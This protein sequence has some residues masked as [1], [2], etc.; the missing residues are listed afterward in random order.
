LRTLPKREKFSSPDAVSALRKIAKLSKWHSFLS[1]HPDPEKRAD[2]L[3]TQ[4]EGKALS[5]EETQQS[6]ISKIKVFLENNF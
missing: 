5:I 2:R 3:Q 4:L 1:S 6:F